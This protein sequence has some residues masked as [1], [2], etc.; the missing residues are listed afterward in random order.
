FM[1]LATAQ[2]LFALRKRINAVHLVLDD[3]ID[4]QRLAADLR[5]HLPTG[6]IVQS[7][8]NRG[9][10][11]QEVLLMTQQGLGSLSVVSLVAGAF[12]I[13]NAFLMNLGERRRQL[14][15][16]RAL[17]ATRRQITRLLLREAVWLGV[18]GTALGIGVGALLAGVALRLAAGLMGLSDR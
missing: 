15:I 14:A 8:T 12:V 3:G 13:L 1:P 7:P 5:E 6:L 10:L 17:G 16:L 9:A 18:T 11:G 2:R 4:P